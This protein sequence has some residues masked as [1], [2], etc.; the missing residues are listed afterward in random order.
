M[1]AT[2]DPT[3]SQQYK[4]L[5][6]QLSG[7]QAQATA[8]AASVSQAEGAAEQSAGAILQSQAALASSSAALASNAAAVASSAAA[9]AAEQSAVNAN[10]ITDGTWTV[11]TDVQPGTYRTSA[12]VSSGACY[13]EITK[14]GTNG[15]DIIQNDI[16]QGGYP[17]VTL[18]VGQD[19][20]TQDCGTWIKR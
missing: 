9:V 18:S 20:K 14:S 2:T 4:S 13:W 3:A 10:S 6:S 17:T 12:A 7:A 5:A 11:G 19:F 15:E 16:V 1:T 8:A